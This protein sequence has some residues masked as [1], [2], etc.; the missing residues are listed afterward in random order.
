MTK[1][2]RIGGEAGAAGAGDLAFAACAVIA[3]I[4]AR[5]GACVFALWIAAVLPA[6]LP[7][8]V[9][10]DELAR[11][12]AA[13]GAAERPVADAVKL[14][15]TDDRARLAFDLSAP[16]EAKAF[17]L[18][19]P[20]RII[21][22]LPEVNFALDPEIGGAPKRPGRRSAS[23]SP[24]LIASYRFGNLGRG[25]SRIVIELAGPAKILRANCETAADGAKARLIIELAKT[26]RA[27][28]RAAVESARSTISEQE[29]T[30]ETRKPAAPAGKPVVMIDPGHGGID[31]GARVNGLV[32]KEIVFDFAKALVA[33]LQ[34]GGR[35]LPLL[36]RDDDTFIPLSERVEIARE[37]NAALFVSIHADIL[38]DAADVAGATVYTVSNRASDAA[39]ARV[40]EKENQSDAAAGLDGSEETNGVSDILSDLTRRETRAYSHV[41]ARTLT[42][43][44]KVAGR[45]NKN[46]QR[47]A[48]FRVLKAPDVPS[49]LL[50]LGYLSNAE[51]DAA[52]NSPEWRDKAAE[53]VAEAICA[54]FSARG[55]APIPAEAAEQ[56]DESAPGSAR[57]EPPVQQQSGL[58]ANDNAANGKTD[59]VAASGAETG[60][61]RSP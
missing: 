3:S 58:A 52:L 23:V 46:P 37:A 8:P 26:D 40:A 44:W 16:I 24:G 60:G 18:S 45:L 14:D 20:D 32:E 50:E 34:A 42:T 61:G 57:S 10:A 41:F 30:G 29:Q 9:A 1:G 13:P 47:S 28:F 2:A 35:V 56:K 22:D 27:A 11:D 59:G 12:S 5:L 4:A 6:A 53:Q 33:K 7:R 55:G 43:H 49:V 48:G 21:I 54:F 15:Q 36:T 38:S 17:A 51:D 19:S 39:S 31:S 25:K